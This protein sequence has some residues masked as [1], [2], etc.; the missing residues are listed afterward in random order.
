[1]VFTIDHNKL[2]RAIKSHSEGKWEFA[3]KEYM[4]IIDEN[5]IYY[6]AIR[7]LGILYFDKKNTV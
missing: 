5:P 3:E 7:H 2:Q 1:M 4:E 6:E